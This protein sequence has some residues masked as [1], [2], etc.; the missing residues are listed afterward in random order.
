MTRKWR[1]NK[2]VMQ[3]ICLFLVDEIHVLNDPTRGAV[4][5]AVISRMKTIQASAHRMISNK[6]IP[7]FRFVALSATITN[8]EDIAS[9]LGSEKSPA[10]HY[11]FDDSAR[12]VRL[13]KVVLGYHFSEGKRSEFQFDI[14]LSYKLSGIINTYNDNKPTLI[15]CA[16]RK[17]VMQ[18][19]DILAKDVKNSYLRN[20]HHRL[21]LQNYSFHLKDAKLRDLVSL[22][23]GYHHA[24][25]D[26][27][28][29]KEIEEIF[30]N[31]D[32]PVLVATS[33][34]AMGVN[35]PA[36]LVIV[37]STMYYNM[38]ALQE[39]SD[40]QM[41]QMIGR[42]GR[43]QF[44]T[45]ATAVIMTK[46][47][48][49]S[50]Y[51]NLIN[52][53][54]VIES[55]L[56]KNLIEHLNAEIVLNTITDISVAVEW[57]KYTF[58]YI[59]VMKNPVFYGI[60]CGLAKVAID[61]RLQDLCLKSLNQLNSL[62]LVDMND[63]NLDIKSTVYGRL[64][65]RYYISFKTAELF[66][67]LKGD[68][69]IID[70]IGIISKCEEF[71]DIKLRVNEKSALNSLNKDKN[72]ITIRFISLI[73][74]FLRY[75]MN[76]KI[77]S[78]DMKV[79]CLIQ[80]TLGCL[81]I[82]DFALQQ[83]AARIFKAGVRVTR[84]LSEL[85][86]QGNNFRLI[87]SSLLLC[88]CFKAKLWENSKFVSK[89]LD[90]IGPTLSTALVNAGLT[91]F[92]KLE[93][94]NPREIELI[95]NRHPPFG[96]QVKDSINRLPKYEMTIEQISR[97]SIV[98]ADV[99]V[100]I[101]LT[102]KDDIKDI[103]HTSHTCTLVIGDE[104]NVTIYKQWIM[105]A[106]LIK[107]G[108]WSKKLEIKRATK[109]PLLNIH[110]ISQEFVGLDVECTYTPYY[111]SGF[112]VAS[113]S[114][115][116]VV[117]LNSSSQSEERN[118]QSTTMRQPCH[119]SCHNKMMCAHECCKIGVAIKSKK[120]QAGSK[121]T[122]IMRNNV[123]RHIE[124]V[125]RKA[126]ILP[127][128]PGINKKSKL[129]V[130]GSYSMVDLTKYRYN[131]TSHHRPNDNTMYRDQPENVDC[132]QPDHQLDD[133]KDYSVVNDT[134]EIRYKNTSSD[135]DTLN[136]Y[137]EKRENITS[138]DNNDVD[139][140]EPNMSDVDYSS[141]QEIHFA[142]V[143][144]G[145]SC[146]NDNDDYARETDYGL[147]YV[148]G[149]QQEHENNEVEISNTVQ[150]KRNYKYQNFKPSKTLRGMYK[151]RVPTRQKHFDN[152]SINLPNIKKQSINQPD[153]HTGDVSDL[154]DFTIDYEID[155]YSDESFEAVKSPQIS[156]MNRSERE[157][158]ETTTE[159]VNT[160]SENV[161][162]DYDGNVPA[163][164]FDY[165]GPLFA[166]PLFK[167][168]AQVQTKNALTVYP[169]SGEN[170]MKKSECVGTFSSDNEYLKN[171]EKDV[172]DNLD[173]QND[174]DVQYVPEDDLCNTGMNH[175]SKWVNFFSS[176]SSTA[177]DCV[178]FKYP[179]WH[180][181]N[182]IV[183]KSLNDV[184]EKQSLSSSTLLSSNKKFTWCAERCNVKNNTTAR[185]NPMKS[186]VLH[187]KKPRERNDCGQYED[188]AMIKRSS[189][190]YPDYSSIFDD[191]L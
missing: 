135:W 130:P 190:C 188:N 134:N 105:D 183:M 91:S 151:S 78:T 97:Y 156:E 64:M 22:G 3:A 16:T 39:Y 2:T 163:N 23:I 28:D 185:I 11:M 60:P 184:H 139:F 27:Q 88:K 21:A 43:P 179:S 48:T 9:W 4:V 41:L 166:R 36:H 155:D 129:Q 71:E 144:T 171:R 147:I 162:A 142:T 168:K 103:G 187:D 119:H 149:G 118:N 133:C 123:A 189:T 13:R 31:G 170:S 92:E 150:G 34:L 18:A 104:D 128:T 19:A 20:S 121:Q 79:N 125:K 99:V 95:V 61:R 17:G 40:T 152:Q 80:A 164:D 112:T 5:E 161:N 176:Q 72:R 157:R 67:G 169:S 120:I 100:T 113:S 117:Q 70:L 160:S 182:E 83:D 85:V 47:T 56:H 74:Y 93:Q 54:Q 110:Y 107:E 132:I 6:D 136:M 35:L 73:C 127:A 38:G 98:K 116:D 62:K 49:K 178:N 137:I 81:L 29:R 7:S 145:N 111:L 115:N 12:P 87:L 37:K 57:I 76:G 30:A 153:D 146:S 108:S 55:S 154:G 140:D 14:S 186:D 124:D 165:N 75:S 50:K 122:P 174:E 106:V 58:L 44:D 52:G 143:P 138:T 102:N 86:S 69:S 159:N 141:N 45:S 32:L 191:I 131:L 84:C 180:D 173:S 15:F 8:I 82:H 175:G 77:K 172:N 66:L 51:E 53:T 33:T 90:G 101:I 89:Q 24:G 59:R 68:E 126:A 25:M 177:S 10:V 65:A 94:A 46:N 42:A 26:I 109:G 63:S 181:R 148:H 167:T 114:M 1:D 158:N 96:N